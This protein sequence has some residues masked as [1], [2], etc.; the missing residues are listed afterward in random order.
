MVAELILCVVGLHDA[1]EAKRVG[2]HHSPHPN[3]LFRPVDAAS[4][5]QESPLILAP[6]PPGEK[7]SI[8]VIDESGENGESG[9]KRFSHIG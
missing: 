7:V 9:V 8:R 5:L 1:V 6:L 4:G 2:I 3:P